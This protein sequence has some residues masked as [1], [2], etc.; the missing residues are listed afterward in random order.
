MW[1]VIA[2]Y[3]DLNFNLKRTPGALRVKWKTLQK[4]TQICLAARFSMANVQRSG[5]TAENM[6][7]LVM[8][9]Y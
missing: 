1:E 3:C 5:M 7:E 2:E 4:E 9:S 8:N 6:Q